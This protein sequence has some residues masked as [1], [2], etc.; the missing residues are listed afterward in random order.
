MK[1]VLS[2]VTVVICSSLWANAQGVTIAD[3]ARRE[4]AKRQAA[5]KQAAPKLPPITNS[6]LQPKTPTRQVIETGDAKPEPTK[7][8]MPA[9]NVAA[10]PATTPIAVAESAAAAANA[11]PAPPAPPAVAANAPSV[12]AAETP[13]EPPRDEKP[14]EP[15]RDEKW[16]RE[17]FEKAR[18]EV[19]RAENQVAVAELEFN[20]A[21]REFLTTSFDPDGRGPAAISA[22]QKKMNDAKQR[23]DDARNKLVQLEEELRRAGAPAGW[24]R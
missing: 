7:T 5:S 3:M 24:A 11:A 4:R 12:P 22:S 6:R 8:G 13:K 19:R 23:L 21:N 18:A 16:W 1:R 20:A 10:G 9:P 15:V 17:R 14:K 2:I